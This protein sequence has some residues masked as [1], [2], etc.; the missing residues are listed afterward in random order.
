[1][2]YDV[3]DS[4]ILEH[5][6]PA[7]ATLSLTLTK[8]SGTTVTPS[9]TEASAGLFR[10]GAA[11]T[12]VAGTWAY[13]WEQ[14]LPYADV[15]T[16]TFTV[17][18]FAPPGYVTLDELKES[19]NI[20]NDTSRDLIL[21]RALGAASRAI[22]SMTGR[23]FWLDPEATT[24]SH[25]T[26]GNAYRDGGRY[27]L[28]VPDIGDPSA[29]TI[30]GRT[31]TTNAGADGWPVATRLYSAAD[32]T[33]DTVSITARLGWPYVPD[34]IAQATLILAGKL[35]KR[36]DSPEGILGSADWGAIRVSRRD[37]DVQMLIEPYT[38]FGVA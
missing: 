12:D 31:V 5:T 28:I 37:P 13:E 11:T 2:R 24:L 30:A 22:D 8:P 21:Q 16:G 35:F 17:E 15:T 4:I 19:L 32:W 33:D 10:S 1:M 26:R 9:V 29:I 34:E 6:A 14:T 20:R 36:K 25:P 3:G 27:A 38:L 7:G 18:T 23:R